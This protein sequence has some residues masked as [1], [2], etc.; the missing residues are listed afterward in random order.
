[1][2]IFIYATYGM[3]GSAQ[4]LTLSL[5]VL[6]TKIKNNMEYEY[7]SCQDTSSYV[8]VK[9]LPHEKRKK[10]SCWNVHLKAICAYVEETLV[11]IYTVYICKW[12]PLE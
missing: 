2:T 11:E 12:P 1:M 9:Y 5:D 7:C 6:C 4:K 10:S 3:E 8:T